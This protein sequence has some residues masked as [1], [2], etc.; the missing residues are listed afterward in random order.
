MLGFGGVS[1]PRRRATFVLATVLGVATLA[2]ASFV[3]AQDPPPTPTSTTT[4]T[5]TT[6]TTAPTT[7]AATTTTVRPTTTTA[8]PTTTTVRPTTT[9]AR[10]TT[11]TVRP[12]TTT[13]A[14][15]PPI[16]TIS[17]E[18]KHNST[19]LDVW[20]LETVLKTLGYQL[21]GPDQ[22]FGTTT[23]N[24]VTAYQRSKG[25]N[26]DGSVGSR[27]GGSLG[28]WSTVSRPPPGT[29]PA[30]PAAPAPAPKQCTIAR[31]VRYGTTGADALCV[32]RKL[33]AL[34]YS[35]DGPDERYGKTS[36]TAVKAYQRSKGLTADGVVGA[37]TAT[38]LGIW[39][40][41]AASA[42]A[43]KPSTPAS[44]GN[45]YGLPANSGTGRRVVYSRA[46]QRVWAVDS[47]GKVVKTHYVS[48]RRYEPY[49]GTYS[50]Y[51]RSMYTYSADNPD[52]KFRYMVRFA[53]GPGGGRIGFHEIPT[54]FGTPLQSNSQ[55]G[56]PLS[57]GCV[58][59]S[60]SDAQWMWNWAGVGTK[61]VVL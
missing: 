19:G 45:T 4:T 3:Y 48:G 42:P 13:A 17:K 14:P 60:T 12:T 55:L 26:A 30:L 5:T 2:D 46:Q 57:G 59:Q 35:L 36:E 1:R 29:A 11:T 6:T 16:C 7:T 24:A 58:R 43:A 53:Y 54:K 50:V 8:R 51:S 20:C 52:I 31:T 38:R 47:S 39:S 40:G 23:V 32:E 33:V 49:A 9:T 18:L 27:T 34:G 28:I 56:Q 44:T 21:T 25:L 22:V 41:P 37:V 10:P 15:K 61:V